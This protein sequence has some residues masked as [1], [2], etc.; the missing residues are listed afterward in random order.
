M[1]LL[2]VVN[3]EMLAWQ[4]AG[5]IILDN[6]LVQFENHR[7]VTNRI[8]ER[9]HLLTGSAI[10]GLVRKRVALITLP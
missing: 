10:N 8:T 1:I 2:I 7:M 6:I 4:A 9:S 3:F 5:K